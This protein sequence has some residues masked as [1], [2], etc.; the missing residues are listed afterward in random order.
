[1]HGRLKEGPRAAVAK[2]MC[3]DYAAFICLYI[4]WYIAT[5][6]AVSVVHVLVLDCNCVGNQSRETPLAWGG[7][8]SRVHVAPMDPALI[9]NNVT[10]FKCSSVYIGAQGP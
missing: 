10:T 1:M 2:I 9:S 5:W 7:L 4:A 3:T 6:L 8:N